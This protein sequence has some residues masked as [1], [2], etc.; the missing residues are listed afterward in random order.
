MAMGVPVLTNSIGIEGIDARDGFEYLHC[1][2][3]EE[4]EETIRL[5]NK[6]SID[7]EKIAKNALNMVNSNYD[8]KKSFLAYSKKVYTL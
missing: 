3:P 1:E 6:G 8:L 4:Y 2:T 5:I 7:S